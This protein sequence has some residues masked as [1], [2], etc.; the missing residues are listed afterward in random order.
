MASDI[1][2]LY[3]NQCAFCAIFEE[4]FDTFVFSFR[5][6][7]ILS[8]RNLNGTFTDILQVLMLGCVSKQ[9]HAISE[10][11]CCELYPHIAAVSN[12]FLRKF[13]NSPGFVRLKLDNRDITSDT[14]ANLTGLESLTIT[15][16]PR[17]ELFSVMSLLTNLRCLKTSRRLESQIFHSLPNLQQLEL[18]TLPKDIDPTRCSNLTCLK[19]DNGYDLAFSR[20]VNIQSLR[21]DG[22]YPRS[23]LR[24]QQFSQAL[25][26]LTCLTKLAITVTNNRKVAPHF[27]LHLTNLRSLDFHP[28]IKL[29]YLSHL[30]GLRSLNGETLKSPYPEDLITIFPNLIAFDCGD[31]RRLSKL[32]Y[33]LTSLTSLKNFNRGASD[34]PVSLIKLTGTEDGR[35]G[36]VSHL[37]NLTQLEAAGVARVGISCLT[38]LTKLSLCI[39]GGRDLIRG[40]DVGKLTNLQKLYFSIGE[41]PDY[42]VAKLPKLIKLKRNKGPRTTIGKFDVVEEILEQ[43]S[44]SSEDESEPAENEEEEDD[45]LLSDSSE[46]D[47]DSFHVSSEDEDEEGAEG[48]YWGGEEILQIL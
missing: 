5:F 38:N 42:V 40:S 27:L 44:Y 11:L 31:S 7:S 6:L 3:Q 10:L 46:S 33:N 32:A 29:E 12:L 43:G 13:A 30:T 16:R 26:T 2:F 15:W 35:L 45:E 28:G 21:I 48:D 20:W 14:L 4:K 24:A 23:A 9:F 39:P 37:T 41:I 8:S 36:C 19:L 18:D 22:F 1:S 47:G 25:G 17:K 34:L